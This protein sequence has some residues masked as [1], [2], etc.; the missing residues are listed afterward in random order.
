ME[1]KGKAEGIKGVADIK[2]RRTS[3][4]SRMSQLLISEMVFSILV[5]K[6]KL[7]RFN[8]YQEPFAEIKP[9]LILKE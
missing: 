4:R 8:L 7:G 6:F 1:G 3:F 9:G 5:S 2:D